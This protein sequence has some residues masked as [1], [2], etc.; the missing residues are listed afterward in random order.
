[1]SKLL[2]T[3]YRPRLSIEIS[4]EQADDLRELIDWGL[5]NKLFSLIVDD[6]IENVRKHGPIFIAAILSRRIKLNKD[7]KFEVVKDGNNQ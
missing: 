1:M 6:V 2:E 4:Q 3:P 5:K 7:A